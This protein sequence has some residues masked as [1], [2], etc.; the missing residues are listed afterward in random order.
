MLVVVGTRGQ[1][2]WENKNKINKTK[3]GF[4]VL[5]KFVSSLVVVLLAGFDCL[6]DK[7]DAKV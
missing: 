1:T 7:D 6:R 2:D 4:T 3:T 5:P